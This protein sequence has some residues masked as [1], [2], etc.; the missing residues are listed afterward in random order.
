MTDIYEDR[1][2]SIATWLSKDDYE[3][4]KQLARNNKVTISTYLRAIITDVLF[5]EGELL[6]A[7]LSPKTETLQNNGR[8]V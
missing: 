5:E 3:K 6:N 2:K 8:V 1:Y 4:L 7:T